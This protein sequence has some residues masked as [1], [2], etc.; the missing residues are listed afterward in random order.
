M[1]YNISNTERNMGKKPM[2]KKGVTQVQMGHMNGPVTLCKVLIIALGINT[3][4][5]GVPSLEVQIVGWSTS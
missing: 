3:E 4:K 1:Y 5:K 2:M